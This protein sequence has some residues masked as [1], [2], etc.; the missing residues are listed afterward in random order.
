[1]CDHFSQHGLKLRFHSSSSLK[2]Y[3]ATKIRSE[4][5][6]CFSLFV[7]SDVCEISVYVQPP[8]LN[9]DPASK[10]QQLL[11]LCSLDV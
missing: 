8:S 9:P 3:L 4:I 2:R 11:K 1:M 6:E 5:T 10:L 7:V